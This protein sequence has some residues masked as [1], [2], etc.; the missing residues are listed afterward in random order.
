MLDAGMPKAQ[1]VNVLAAANFME[2][3]INSGDEIGRLAPDF[4]QAQ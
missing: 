1:T 2:L 3:A 4:V